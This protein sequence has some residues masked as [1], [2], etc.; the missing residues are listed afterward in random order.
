MG[1]RSVSGVGPAKGGDRPQGHAQRAQPHA[2][3]A[4]NLAHNPLIIFI[5]F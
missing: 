4:H 3:N 2:H 1:N 5:I